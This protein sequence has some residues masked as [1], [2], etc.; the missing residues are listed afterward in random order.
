MGDT[1]TK[2]PFGRDSARLS[3]RVDDALAAGVRA[4]ARRRRT[5]VAELVREFV[6]TGIGGERRG[7]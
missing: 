5:T 2:A 6:L 3:V 7:S 1:L 4:E